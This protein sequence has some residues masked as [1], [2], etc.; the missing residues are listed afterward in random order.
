MSMHKNIPPAICFAFLFCVCGRLAAVDPAVGL[1]YEEPVQLCELKNKDINESSGIAASH[2]APNRF[3]THNDSGDDARLFCFDLKG[4]HLGTS[5]LKK[6]HAID[7]EDMCSFELDGQPKLLVADTGDNLKRRRVYLLH[8][9]DEPEDPSKDIKDVRT[10]QVRYSVGSVDCEAVAFDPV[11]REFIFVEKKYALTCRV[12]R[13]PFPAARESRCTAELI[14]SIR[15]PVVTAMDI[16]P[17][18]SRAIVMTVGQAFEYTR[19]ANQT[20]A[21]ALRAKPN[22][23]GLPP[24]RQGEAI[25]FG[26]GGRDLFLTSEQ[27]PTPLFKVA[28]KPD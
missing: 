13:A 25:C 10:I 2:H 17:D 21:D 20:W 14:G 1:Q 27:S 3:W 8:L 5:K 26:R 19:A 12:F 9:V 4:E 15:I 23:V 28:A 24:R 6:V 16:S 11:L 18:G 22:K 7:W